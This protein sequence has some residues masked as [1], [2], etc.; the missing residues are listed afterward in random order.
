MALGLGLGL[1]VREER[2]IRVVVACLENVGIGCGI[3]AKMSRF[4]ARI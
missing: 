2:R 4:G 3:S 1:V